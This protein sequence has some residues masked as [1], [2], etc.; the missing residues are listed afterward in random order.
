MSC[1]RWEVNLH[2]GLDS[3]NTVAC[4]TKHAVPTEVAVS[5]NGGS[6][7]IVGFEGRVMDLQRRI[8]SE[9]EHVSLYDV[10]CPELSLVS[11]WISVSVGQ[12][13]YDWLSDAHDGL[14]HTPFGASIS[15]AITAN[16]VL[17]MSKSMDLDSMMGM[18]CPISLASVGPRA[19][20]VL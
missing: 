16:Q 15:P 11:A 4:C 7:D 20:Q 3:G 12:M 14:N 13:N 8:T 6:F 5:F 18:A 2:C 9:V 19:M 1:V 10:I 17:S